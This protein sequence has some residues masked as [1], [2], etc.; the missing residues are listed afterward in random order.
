MPCLSVCLSVSPPVRPS[1]RHMLK[2]LA[3]GLLKEFISVTKEV[4][5]RAKTT[6]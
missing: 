2:A 4:K 1:V 3:C 5:Q 6:A